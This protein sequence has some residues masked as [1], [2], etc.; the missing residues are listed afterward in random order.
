MSFDPESFMQQTVDAPMATEFLVVPEGEYQAIIGDF[1][2]DAFK[3][4]DFTYKKGP[5]AGEP[6]SMTVFNC[7]FK[8][9]DAALKAS[10]ER[11][12]VTAYG[13]FT[14]DFEADGSLSTKEGRNVTLGQLRAAVGQ[15]QPGWTFSQLRGQGPVM[16]KVTHRSDDKNPE[17]KYAEVTRVAPIR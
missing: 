6:G 12:E 10:M 3:S 17:R 7:P 2:S 4:F 16:V 1:D 15:N 14:L 9:Q 11:D 13:R 5:R 8:I